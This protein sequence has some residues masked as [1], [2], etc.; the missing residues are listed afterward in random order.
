MSRS[1]TIATSYNYNHSQCCIFERSVYITMHVYGWARGQ[2]YD[3]IPRYFADIYI[4]TIYT[5]QKAK[6]APVVVGTI[7][8][9][10]E[11]S[12]KFDMIKE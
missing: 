6:M 11:S 12:S 9:L 1:T 7:N 2:V 10:Y 4:R 5:F 3:Y 8:Y